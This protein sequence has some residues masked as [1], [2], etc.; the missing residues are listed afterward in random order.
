MASRSHS[1]A[2][3]LTLS[4]VDD[5]DAAES[6]RGL[7]LRIPENELPALPPGEFYR[8]QLIGC[9]ILAPDTPH[10]VL[11]VLDDILDLPGQEIWRI[12]HESGQEILFPA[13]PHTVA[14]IDLENAAITVTPPP[15]LVEV[16]LPGAAAPGPARGE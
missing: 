13:N 9:R 4:G 16:Y 11:G 6:L 2:L 10:P 5:R 12:L 14:A 8:R 7:L 1:G 15:G 3:L